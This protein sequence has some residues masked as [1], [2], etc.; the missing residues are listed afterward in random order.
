MKTKKRLIAI[1]LIAVIMSSL[2]PNLISNA[3][4]EPSVTFSKTTV[5]AEVGD[6]VTV[7]INLADGMANQKN[8]NFIL[9]YDSTALEAIPDA[10]S[11][12]EKTLNTMKMVDDEVVQGSLYNSFVNGS[13]IV[14]G[15]VETTEITVSYTSDLVLQ[16]SGKIA[17]LSFKVLKTGPST[18]S[19]AEIEYNSDPNDKDG[20]STDITSSSQ[21]TVN[22]IIKMTDFTIDVDVKEEY[23]VGQSDI[24]K[25]KKVP[26]NATTGGA[27]KWT[28][29]DETVAKIGANNVLSMV[30]PGTATITAECNGIK[31]SFN[32]VVTNPI[33]GITL[34]PEGPVTIHKGDFLDVKAGKDPVNTTTQGTFE[35]SSDNLQVATVDQNGRVTAVGVGQAIITVKYANKTNSLIVT[36]DAPLKDISLKQ[37]EVALDVNDIATLEVVSNPIDTTEAYTVTW[38]S[39]DNSIAEVDA[40]GIVTGKGHGQATITATVITKTAGTKTATAKVTCNVHLET[41]DIVNDS[42]VNNNL[43]LKKG[44]E[45]TLSI[46]YKPEVFAETKT[47]KWESSNTAVAI[48]ENG[49]VKAIAPGTAEITA[50]SVNGKTDKINVIVPEV[51]LNTITITKADATIEKGNTEKLTVTI[52]PEDTTDDTTVTWK[53]SDE[54]VATVDANG[55]VTAVAPGT[56]T[57]TAS[58]AGKDSDGCVITVTCKLE[59]I[60]L[61]KEKMTLEAG[62]TSDALAV[63][64]NPNDAT[65]DVDDATWKSLNE[66]VATVDENGVV[67]AIAPG[68]AVIQVNLNGETAEC[69]VTVIVTLTG[70]EIENSSETLEMK[71]SQTAELKVL[72]TPSNATEIPDATW[73]SSD[74]EIVAVDKN[75]KLKALK[76]GTATITVDYGNGITS[77]RK[78]NVT[79]VHADEVVFDKIIESLNKGDTAVLVAVISPEESTDTITWS[80]SDEKIATVDENGNVKALKA[81]EVTITATATNGKFASMNIKV[82]EVAVESVKATTKDTIV[83]EGETTQVEI[84]YNPEDT[85]DDVIVTYISSNESI[86]TVDKNGKVTAKKAGKVVITA[87]V[88]AI[89]GEGEITEF[90]TQTTLNVKEKPA[91]STGNGNDGS[92]GGTPAPSAPAPVAGLTTSPHTGDMNIVA[93]ASMMVISLVG[94]VLIVRKK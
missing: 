76:E 1:L 68:K 75:G 27:A 77:S 31:K 3:E 45:A 20:V 54:S 42:L 62:K 37:T 15:Y 51:K 49:I 60:K 11:G 24:L 50:T 5:D 13:G 4:T 29:S 70:V 69:E 57:I 10:I 28:S 82:K 92:V 89:N 39:S 47:I 44:K 58:A 2:M 73:K 14:R 88:K 34:D 56:A 6:I 72:Y 83:E 41:I 48:V 65:V 86:A 64:K 38:S 74:E 67:K 12:E 91:P 32:V 40:N 63:I 52:T 94:M 90:T 30:G 93:L 23:Q 71:K 7:D 78:V 53:S 55:V 8:F 33:I 81:G 17:T 46:D 59:S 66:E 36:V 9:N 19:F 85:T 21:F 18:V 16:K 26:Y 80:S 22:G 61:D 79:E 25:I 84:T 43:T 87:K 35:W